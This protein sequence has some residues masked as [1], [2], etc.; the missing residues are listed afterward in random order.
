LAA[1]QQTNN[2]YYESPP[3]GQI[4]GQSVE[5][6]VVKGAQS[7]FSCNLASYLQIS[8]CFA[9]LLWS[10]R[11]NWSL[12]CACWLQRQYMSMRCP[13]ALLLLPA[14]QSNL[15]VRMS[16]LIRPTRLTCPTTLSGSTSQSLCVLLVLWGIATI[17]DKHTRVS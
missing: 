9:L 17:L 15:P 10:Q 1:K 14:Q 16:L 12:Y 2:V 13:M 6:L 8:L 5:R 3:I 11:W 7:Q 4:A